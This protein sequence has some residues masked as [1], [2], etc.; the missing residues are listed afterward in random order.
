MRIG[1]KLTLGFGLLVAM[2]IL[3]ISLSYLAS[4]RATNNIGETIDVRAPVALETGLAQANLLRMVAAVR[5]YLALGEPIYRENYAEAETAFRQ[6]LRRLLTMAQERGGGS[7]A[8]RITKLEGVVAEWQTQPQRLFDLHDDQLVREPAL[9]ILLEDGSRPI[10]IIAANLTKLI[11][12][13]GTREPTLENLSLLIDMA[14]LQSSFLAMIAGLRGYVTTGRDNFKFEYA[15]NKQINDRAWAALDRRKNELAQSQKLSFDMLSGARETFAPLPEKMFEWVEGER[16]RMDLFLFRTDAVPLADTMLAMLDEIA[17]EEQQLLR[18]G[19]GEGRSELF[20]AQ[21]HTILIGAVAGVLGIALALFFR[22]NIVG[23][24]RRL[25]SVAEQVD[26]GHLGAEARVES[27][28]EIGRLAQTF[29][30]MRA[31]LGNSLADLERR[32]QEQEAA[33]K[34]LQI[35]S[36]KLSKYLSPQVYSSIFAGRQ[37]VKIASN[38]KKLTIF[39]SDIAGFTATADDLE[40]EELTGLLNSYLTEMS[41]IALEHGATIDKYVGDAIVIFFGDPET[42]GIKEDAQACVAMAIAM[43]KRMKELQDQWRAAG[44]ERPFELRIGINTGY[45]T[46]GNFGSEDRMD[47]TIIGNEVNLAARLQANAPLG[48]ILLAH[49]TYS[50]VGVEFPCVER[51]P[52]R[53]KG[54]SKPVRNYEVVPAGPEAAR[55]GEIDV[56]ASGFAMHVDFRRLQAQDHDRIVTAVRAALDRLIRH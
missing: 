44:L 36:I 4:Q 42:K 56:E 6:N 13:Q 2:T 27:E 41:R 50:L 49:E 35:L 22:S 47:Y 7:L 53:V 54:F 23:P 45:C 48:G 15:S 39:F 55:S 30:E 8:N 46:V 14:E 5:G 25:T 37:E 9:R 26:A 18:I 11:A 43:L 28:D 29:N 24:V 34:S 33:A 20:N 17:V 38:R 10:A 21:R 19:L 16:A 51:D 52:I 12:T 1:S 32:R 31:R 3:V 40:S